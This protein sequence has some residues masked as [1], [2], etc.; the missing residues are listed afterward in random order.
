MK[1]I[2]LFLIA[3]M[4][5]VMPIRADY[6]LSFVESTTTSDGSTAYSMDVSKVFTDASNVVGEVTN[7]TSVYPAKKGYGAKFGSSKAAGNLKFTLLQ[8]TY[9]AAI[10]KVAAYT[11]TTSVTLNV[12]GMEFPLEMPADGSPMEVTYSPGASFESMEISSNYAFLS[13]VGDPCR[14]RFFRWWN[15]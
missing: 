4:A 11:T 9:V 3:M 15:E 8:P 13:A 1:K 12:N 14:A 7:V 5:A 2:A 6:T 10:L